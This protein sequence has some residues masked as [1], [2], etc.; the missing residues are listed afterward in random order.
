MYRVVPV[1]GAR[2]SELHN[3][4]EKFGFSAPSNSLPL[5]R[6]Q[7]KL[8]PPLSRHLLRCPLRP[9][10]VVPFYFEDADQGNNVDILSDLSPIIYEPISRTI[11]WRKYVETTRL[12]RRNLPLILA[13]RFQSYSALKDP[14]T[15]TKASLQRRPR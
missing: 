12:F 1:L 3:L 9:M 13:A 8:G 14:I 7:W 10:I 15:G 4:T 5:E 11:G 2:F 6:F